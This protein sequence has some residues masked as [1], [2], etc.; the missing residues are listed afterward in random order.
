MSFTV[1]LAGGGSG[2]HIY[3]SIAVARAL[4][5]LVPDL[6]AVFVG[7]ERGL[8]K[9]IVPRAGFELELLPLEPFALLTLGVALW[10]V[11]FALYMRHFALTDEQRRLVATLFPGKETRFLRAFGVV[12]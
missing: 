11:A 5:G 7:T 9:D 8:E 3:P 12:H 6:R 1:L 2:G 4:S 10:S